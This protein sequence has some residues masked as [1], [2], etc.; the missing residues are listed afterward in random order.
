[1]DDNVENSRNTLSSKGPKYVSATKKTNIFEEKQSV[2]H[3]HDHD[4]S[5][6]RAV[7]SKF[8][9]NALFDSLK[10]VTKDILHEQL[11]SSSKSNSTLNLH[12]LIL[13]DAKIEDK[14]EK[15]SRDVIRNTRTERK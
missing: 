10:I 13:S 7:C 6:R 12:N 15:C 5:V 8:V 11:K 2:A 14:D 3:D 9:K 1:M 4:E